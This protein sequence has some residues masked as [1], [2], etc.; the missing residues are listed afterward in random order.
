MRWPLH[1]EIKAQ[2]AVKPSRGCW[3]LKGYGL[4]VSWGELPQV[5]RLPKA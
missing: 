5:G 4:P 2:N 3:L 1:R